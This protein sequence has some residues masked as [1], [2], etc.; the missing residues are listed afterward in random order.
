ML[1]TLDFAFYHRKFQKDGW[2]HEQLDRV[3]VPKNNAFQH[4]NFSKLHL[5]LNK[6]HNCPIS[7]LYS[8][9]N[10]DA[11]IDAFCID[12]HHE[13]F[14]FKSREW[15]CE[16]QVNLL[17]P[18]SLLKVNNFPGLFQYNYFD[19][20]QFMPSSRPKL[21]LFLNQRSVADHDSVDLLYWISNSKSDPLRYIDS[22][23]E[24]IG[25]SS[26][27]NI[28]FIG[29]VKNSTYIVRISVKINNTI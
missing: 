9:I 4:Q 2:G 19:Q 18:E 3:L 7:N 25:Y 17:M 29:P 21:H 13:V 5:N 12:L 27:N 10:P 26:Q 23:E 24:K 11:K 1:R 22:W 20:F 16:I 6:Y 8:P 28:H 15:Q 14:L